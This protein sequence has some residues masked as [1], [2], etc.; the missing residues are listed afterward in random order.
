MNQRLWLILGLLFLAAC[1]SVDAPSRSDTYR[2]EYRVSGTTRSADLTYTN[3]T[4]DTEQADRQ[5]TPWDLEFDARSGQFLYISAQNNA[6]SGTVKCQIFVNGI[7]VK[8]AES[9]GA[10]VIATCSGIL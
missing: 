10:Y 9:R 5:F 6:E 1:S 2:I 4:G 3:R 7:E 8:Q